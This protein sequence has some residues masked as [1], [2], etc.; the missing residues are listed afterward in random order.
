MI[1]IDSSVLDACRSRSCSGSLRS[2][3]HGY[4]RRYW[5]IG[6]TLSRPKRKFDWI[7]NSGVSFYLRLLFAFYGNVASANFA[8]TRKLIDHL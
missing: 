4:I 1:A 6:K 7:G 3:W 2:L 8:I 5:S